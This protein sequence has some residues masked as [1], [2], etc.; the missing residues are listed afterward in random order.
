MIRKKHNPQTVLVEE[1][2]VEEPTYEIDAEWLEDVLDIIGDELG[3]ED[4]YLND[5]HLE[6][7]VADSRDRF[8]RQSG[9]SE[10]YEDDDYDL[11]DVLEDLDEDELEYV[12]EMGRKMHGDG[13]YSDK[14]IRR[15]NHIRK[16]PRGRGR[17]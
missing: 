1:R 3:E 5:A 15:I 12:I 9:L 14:D 2:V 7:L 13:A 8:N 4:R 11:I 16:N 10:G 6:R 17:G